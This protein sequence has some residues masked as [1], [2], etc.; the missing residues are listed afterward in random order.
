LPI[1]YRVSERP[2]L[3]RAALR[4]FRS[5]PIE[6]AG[7]GAFA[8]RLPDLAREENRRLPM[9]DNPGSAYLQAL[10]E[11]GL[12]GFLLTVGFVVSL[13]RQALA[14]PRRSVRG[15]SEGASVGIVAFLLTLA[16][17]SH[18]FAPDGS[19]L[20]FLLASTVVVSESPERPTGTRIARAA[21]WLYGA[22]AVAGMLSTT[23]P[24]E[25]FRYSPSIGFHA[26]E[27][28]PNGTRRWTRRCFAL[29]IR[30]GD[31]LRLQLAHFTPESRPL[32]VEAAVHGR[33]VWHRS[34][35]PGEVTHLILS[36]SSERPRAV[37]FRVS[38][39]FVPRRWGLSEDRRELGLLSAEE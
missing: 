38:R 39:A 21:V 16:L 26:P 27:R 28:G 33:I 9:R 29:W 35:A 15:A 13:A 24:E 12:I 37:V 6:G 18:W 36:G 20:F 34:L 17:G 19:R 2:A 11:T 22:A 4:L 31:S 14:A 23:R 30:P 7:M 25:T 5:D 3:W 8:W 1:E 32:D 10:A